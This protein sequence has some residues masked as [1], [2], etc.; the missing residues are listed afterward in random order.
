MSRHGSGSVKRGPRRS[1]VVAFASILALLIAGW[2]VAAWRPIT[3]PEPSSAVY[4]AGREGSAVE[5]STVEGLAPVSPTPGGQ[6]PTVSSVLTNRATPTPRGSTGASSSPGVPVGGSHQPCRPVR[7]T[8]PALGIDAPIV[9]LSLTPDGDLGTPREADRAS[10]GWFPSVLAGAGRG[11]VLMD[12][13]T[14]R[15]GSALFTPA[16]TQQVRTGMLMRLSCADGYAFSY[17]VSELT[18]DISAANYPKFVERR[19]LY[20]AEGPSQLVMITCT[21]YVPERRVW[22]N[23]AIIIATPVG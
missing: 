18:L 3:T 19:A 6:Q 10:A 7:F 1:S 17:Q 13:H 8:M 21:D 9:G 23:R 14:Y 4:A 12:G 15:D 11:T 2:Y 5:K 16:F 20:S 22:A